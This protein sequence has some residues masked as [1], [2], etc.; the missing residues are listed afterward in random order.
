MLYWQKLFDAR[1][2]SYAENQI[3]KSLFQID[4]VDGDVPIAHFH[5][6]EDG[7]NISEEK[8]ISGNEEKMEEKLS[9]EQND[10]EEKK[11]NLQKRNPFVK[12]TFRE[13]LLQI[14]NHQEIQKL[15]L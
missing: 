14:L 13:N 2:C 4:L 9:E 11:I 6:E 12:N 10:K 15:Y 1:T 3:E 7:Y 8:E 5:E